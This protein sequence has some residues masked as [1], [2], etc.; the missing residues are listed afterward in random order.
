VSDPVK[1]SLRQF[2]WPPLA[3]TLTSSTGGYGLIG[4]VVAT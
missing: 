4:A 1:K 3:L 2:G